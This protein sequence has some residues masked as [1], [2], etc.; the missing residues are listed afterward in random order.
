MPTPA[1]ALKKANARGKQGATGKRRDGKKARQDNAAARAKVP[2]REFVHHVRDEDKGACDPC[3][4]P[5]SRKLGEG[6]VSTI[7]EFVPAA[8]RPL[9]AW[10]CER[11][12]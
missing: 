1:D 10:R 6:Q 12:G 2:M 8:A 7:Y 3:G 4:A 11:R 9:H 5:A